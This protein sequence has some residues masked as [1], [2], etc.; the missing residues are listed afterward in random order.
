MY[1]MREPLGPGGD[2][3]AGLPRLHARRVIVGSRVMGTA[4]GKDGDSGRIPCNSGSW[5]GA[6]GVEVL[7][8]SRGVGVVV[9]NPR[10]SPG[11][12]GSQRGLSRT[13]G[14]RGFPGIRVRCK[15]EGGLHP[16]VKVSTCGSSREDPG[17]IPGEVLKRGGFPGPGEG[18]GSRGC[19]GKRPRMPRGRGI[20][21]GGVVECPGDPDV[22][23]GFPGVFGG[24][25]EGAPE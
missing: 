19:S 22:T 24:E 12:G 18:A 6:R 3:V 11:G 21:E 2:G 17:P 7:P 16:G 13:R 5:S 20:E 4:G 10:P 25:T 15:W 8:G 23:E 1:G 9:V 14:G